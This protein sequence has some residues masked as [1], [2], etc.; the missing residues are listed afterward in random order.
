MYSIINLIGELY[1]TM[2]GGVFHYKLNRCVIY[3]N[4]GVVY[5]II[6]LIGVLYITMRGGVFHYKLA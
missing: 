4:E 5:S 6:N 3:Y 1:I 2:R